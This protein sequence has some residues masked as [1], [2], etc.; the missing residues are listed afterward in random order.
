MMNAPAMV[1][2]GLPIIGHGLEMLRDREALFQRGYAEHGKMFSLKIGPRRAVVL[3]GSDYNRFVFQETDKRLNVQE[4]YEFIRPAFG[5]NFFIVSN[6]AYLNMRPVLQ[7]IFGHQRMVGYVEAMNKEVQR[8]LNSLGEEGET[9]L[10]TDMLTLTAIRQLS[11]V[12]F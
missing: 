8:W 4:G 2:G 10:S 1:S 12:E 5:D 6:E 11:C 3:T 9:D 7:E